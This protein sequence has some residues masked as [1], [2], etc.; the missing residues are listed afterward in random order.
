[1]SEVGE[2]ESA[3]STPPNRQ[4]VSLRSQARARTCYSGRSG[5]NTLRASVFPPGRL[6]PFLCT[7][8][9]VLSVC[10]LFV[11]AGHLF[12]VGFKWFCGLGCKGT[13]VLGVFARF[14]LLDSCFV[15]VVRDFMDWGLSF[16][17]QAC[18][19]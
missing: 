14:G 13:W 9:F 7:V 1:M 17:S 4:I 2:G 18:G 12:H 10:S 16:C 3:P 6:V 11:V 5:A 19:F 8:M 15:R